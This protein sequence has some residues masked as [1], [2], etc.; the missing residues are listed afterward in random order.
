M[1]M[2]FLH[3]ENAVYGQMILIE[4]SHAVTL[5]TCICV[6]PGSIPGLDTDYSQ[7]LCSFLQ[8]LQVNSVIIP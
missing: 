5:L 3:K 1:S 7:V 8:F 6:A 4:L 2:N